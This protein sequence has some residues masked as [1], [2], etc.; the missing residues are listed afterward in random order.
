[1]TKRIY[2]TRVIPQVG[3]DILKK[4]TEVLIGSKTFPTKEELICEVKNCHVLLT[5]L[6]EKIDKEILDAN[7]KLLG[8]V[9]YAVG[10]NNIDIE[11]A[12][13]LGIP[14]TNTPGVLTDTTADLAWAL[15]LSV[16]RRIPQAHEFTQQGKFITWE[17]NLFLG[18][19][20]SCGGN[21]TSKVLGIIGYGR[22]G[23]AVIK[24]A[25]G[26]DMK[27]FVH[28]PFMKNEILADGFQYKGLPELFKESDVI[29]IHANLTDKTHHLIGENLL[30][31]AKKNLILINTSRGPLIDEKALTHALREKW[32]FGAGFDVYEFEP[33]LTEGLAKLDNVVILP[34]IGSASFDTRNK[35]A[36]MAANNALALL[37]MKEAPNTVN[38][39]AYKT[40]AYKNKLALI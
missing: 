5:L 19:D 27:V 30:K 15:I 1:M 4:E 26:F 38:P 37:K 13:R 24:R 17:A 21:E 11:Y 25:K 34:H 22:I 31:I 10:Y 28:D 23:K 16:A 18:Q 40:E 35:M 12:T 29:S 20:I 33:K 7:P 3:I 9:N 8:I 6:T 36:T 39:E 2:V 32:I 14:V